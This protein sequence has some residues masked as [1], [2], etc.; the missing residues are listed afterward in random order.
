MSNAT[1]FLEKKHP[2]IKAVIDYAFD[3]LEKQVGHVVTLLIVA[4]LFS[5]SSCR[6]SKLA[7]KVE[8]LAANQ[9]N[10]INYITP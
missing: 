4:A 9:T 10:I 7:D 1:E 6:H 8:S 2:V 3:L 5:F